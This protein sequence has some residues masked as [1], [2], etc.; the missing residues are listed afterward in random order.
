MSQLSHSKS[1]TM[2][3]QR[4]YQKSKQMQSQAHWNGANT[5]KHTP[6]PIGVSQNNSRMIY[7][8]EGSTIAY[9]RDGGPPSTASKSQGQSFAR[10]TRA[11]ARNGRG[12]NHRVFSG[13]SGINENFSS[14]VSMDHHLNTISSVSHQMDLHNKSRVGFNQTVLMQ[15]PPRKMVETPGMGSKSKVATPS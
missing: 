9:S 6:K 13:A 2:I 14:K 8:R 10:K 11:D 3:E 4:Q 12:M 7:S 15:M 1:P 5:N